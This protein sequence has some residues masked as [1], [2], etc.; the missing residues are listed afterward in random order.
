[1]SLQDESHGHRVP[2]ATLP[3]HTPWVSL[4]FMLVQVGQ[5]VD[6]KIG[7]Y[8]HCVGDVILSRL[9]LS[10]ARCLRLFF[11][12]KGFSFSNGCW[13][14]ARLTFAVWRLPEDILRGLEIKVGILSVE[15][16]APVLDLFFFFCFA[17][18]NSD[19]WDVYR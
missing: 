8:S 10:L 13:P 1:M 5:V 4:T 11:D 16:S 12:I 14:L 17:M 15:E 2:F 18:V 19:V 9:S 7:H 6:V 3:V